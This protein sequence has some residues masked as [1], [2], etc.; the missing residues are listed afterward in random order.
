M[1]VG[2]RFERSQRA[3]A[4]GRWELAAYD[5]HELREVFE[6]DLLPGKWA[7][8]PSMGHETH[9]FIAGPL[10]QLEAAARDRSAWDGAFGTTVKACNACHQV[11]HVAFIEIDAA[12]AL[13]V[14]R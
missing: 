9:A 2:A 13:R 3:V 14:A 11:A 6:D 7:D 10:P 8:N 5:V 12:G 1:E 4:A